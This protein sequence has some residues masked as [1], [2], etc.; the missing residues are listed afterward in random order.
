MIAKL[1]CNNRVE[2]NKKLE[3]AFDV[4][5]INEW[6]FMRFIELINAY[7]DYRHSLHKF[8]MLKKELMED[9]NKDFGDFEGDCI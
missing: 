2:D 3:I 8:K 9:Y 7:D 4:K 5:P 6:K 1:I